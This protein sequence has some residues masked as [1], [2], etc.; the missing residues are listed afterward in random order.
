MEPQHDILVIALFYIYAVVW[1]G[2]AVYVYYDMAVVNHNKSSADLA[3][4]YVLVNSIAFFA[5]GMMLGKQS[6]ASFYFAVVVTAQNILFTLMNLTELF[7]LSCFIV[8]ALLLWLLY[9]LRGSYLS[10]I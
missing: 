5:S 4:I 10:K 9:R 1:F 3:T 8:D 7:F 6:K 2:Y